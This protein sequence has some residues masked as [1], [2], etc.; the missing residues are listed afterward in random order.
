MDCSKA[1]GQHRI[2]ERG[3]RRRPTQPR[4]ITTMGQPQN[5]TRLAPLHKLSSEWP[6]SPSRVTHL[7]EL[8]DGGL[9]PFRG[10]GLCATQAPVPH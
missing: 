4:V 1:L 2:V 6:M 8:P 9:G 3:S 5:A 7:G 10:R